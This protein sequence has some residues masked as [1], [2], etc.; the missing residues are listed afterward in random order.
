MELLAQLAPWQSPSVDYHALA[1]E[2]VLSLTV[3]V[4]LI[5]DLFLPERQKWATST[6]AGLGLLASLVPILTLAIDGTD[7]VMFGG[8]YVVDNF[9]LVLKTLFLLTG[10]RRGAAVD[11]VRRGGRLLPGRVLL[12]AALLRARHGDDELQPRS[13]QHL[14]RPR[15]AV[16]P[17]LPARG[18]AQAGRAQ[19]R[20]GCQ[21]LPARR[22]RLRRDAVRDVAVLRHH[23]HDAPPGRGRGRRQGRQRDDHHARRGLHRRRLRVQGVGGAVPHLGAR[24]LRGG[25]DAGD[26][27]PVRG[28]E[29][30]GVRRPRHP[31]LRRLP[32]RTRRVP[33]HVL[34]AVGPHD[35]G[36]QRARPAPDQHRSH[37]GLL[38]DQ[39]GRLHP[40]AAGRGRRSERAE[41]TRCGPSSPT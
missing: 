23:G 35:D 6:I 18:V 17:G 3:V 33:A 38:L 16:D 20:G 32:V 37:A 7:R 27:L 31:H 11:D 4:L 29:G 26:G 41:P 8:G 14:R 13:G 36:R 24:H 30:G 12:L 2:I 25:A 21:V 9:A 1:P 22:V 10:V 39:P 15:A 40:D 28:V 5:A 34:G 19:Q